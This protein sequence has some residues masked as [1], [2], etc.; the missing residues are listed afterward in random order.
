[1]SMRWFSAL[2]ALLAAVSLPCGT[3]AKPP[4]LPVQ[5][6]VDCE[7][8]LPPWVGCLS[9]GPGCVIGDTV[10][11]CWRTLLR[12]IP[13]T[14][15]PDCCAEPTTRLG[16]IEI[17][18]V[19]PKDMGLPPIMEELRQI[20]Y[21]WERIWF[22]DQPSHLTP[23]RVHGGIGSDAA[24]FEE[25]RY[26]MPPTVERLQVA[27]TRVLFDVVSTPV[28]PVGQDDGSPWYCIRCIGK[29][30]DGEFMCLPVVSEQRCSECPHMNGQATPRRIVISEPCDLSNCVLENFVKLEKAHRLYRKAEDCRHEGRL[31]EACDC[32]REAAKLCPGSRCSMMCASRVHELATQRASGIIQASATEPEAE[33]KPG[34]WWPRIEIKLTIEVKK[35]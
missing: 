1:M 6:K 12:W 27:P 20:E 2:F 9:V 3:V 33:K 28:N 15:A 23:Q 24:F 17:L 35:Q 26:P 22:A 32:Y 14:C 11:A 5:S 16:V 21:L 29:W 25:P 10:E 18:P 34:S 8:P 19:M 7:T 30:L 4:D 31:D 13:V